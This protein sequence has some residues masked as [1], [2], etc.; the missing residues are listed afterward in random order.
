MALLDL[1]IVVKVK[2]QKAT[3][4]LGMDSSFFSLLLYFLPLFPF[5]HE[6]VIPSASFLSFIIAWLITGVCRK[7]IMCCETP[8]AILTTVVSHGQCLEEGGG[9]CD[10]NI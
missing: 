9:G 10:H 1:G 3:G 7:P 4:N 5:L 6:S 2:L 8:T